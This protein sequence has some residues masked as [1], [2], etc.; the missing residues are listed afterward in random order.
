M[1]ALE[2]TL[3]RALDEMRA[4]TGSMRVL[5]RG[6][7]WSYLDKLRTERALASAGWLRAQADHAERGMMRHGIAWLGARA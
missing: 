5:L 4:S 6:I 1:N 3:D 7:A 2:D